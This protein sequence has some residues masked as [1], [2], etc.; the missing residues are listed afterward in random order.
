MFNQEDIIVAPATMSGGALSIIRLSGSGRV[1]LVDGVFSRDL[2]SAKGYTLHYG[3]ILDGQTLLDDVMLS[4]FRAPHSYTGEESV[5]I[6]CHGS[7]YIVTSI[8]DL[9]L[10]SGARMANAG[11]FTVRAFLAGRIDLSQAEAVSDL[12]AST[13]HSMHKMASTQMRGGYSSTLDTLR[14]ELVELSALLELELDF[15]EEDV[16]FA[17]RDSLRQTMLRLTSE[18]VRLSESFKVGNAI[19]RGLR[20]AIVGAPNVG[21]STLL[22]RLLGED[23]AMVSDVAGTTRD[24]IEDTIIIEGVTVRF[25]DTAGLHT[26]EDQLERMGIERTM[27]AMEDADVVLQIID[28]TSQESPERLKLSLDQRLIVV[29][30]K[31]DLLSETTKR[32]D[33]LY[34]SAKMSQGIEALKQALLEGIDL[35]SLYAGDSIVSNARHYEHLRQASASL[36]HTIAALDSALPTDLLLEDLRHT[37]HHI[38]SI[39]GSITTDEILGKIFSS[40]CIGK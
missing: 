16:E 26:T 4:V 9:L 30:N 27:A 29:E 17:N 8:I 40:F 12:I 22:N 28:A 35:E 19:K 33:R 13:S 36:E 11:E 38:G 15:S 3:N 1:A 23:R 6:T 24:T 31:A 18:I 7:S 39:T 34:I 2:S 5:E 32:G 14:N 37:L 21:K 20:V 10:R 25:I